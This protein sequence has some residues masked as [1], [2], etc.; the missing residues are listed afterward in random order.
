MTLHTRTIA[1][2]PVTISTSP[3]GHM[4]IATEHGVYDGA[5]DTK[6][7]ASLIGSG[8]TEEAAIADLVEQLEDRAEDSALCAA[9]NAEPSTSDTPE[10]A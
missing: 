8:V 10:R 1:G 9:R 3:H 4:T 2:Q 7:R 6:G 5:P